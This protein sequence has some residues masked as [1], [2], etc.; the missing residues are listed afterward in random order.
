MS[1]F[2][3]VISKLKYEEIAHMTKIKTISMDN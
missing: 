1:F 3:L 2:E